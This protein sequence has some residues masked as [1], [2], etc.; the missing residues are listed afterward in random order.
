MDVVRVVL[1]IV[2]LCG[3][4][5]FL[6]LAAIGVVRMPDVFLRISAVSKASTLGVGCVLLATAVAS[7]DIGVRARAV[8]TVA[9]VFLTTPVASHM[10]GRAAYRCGAPLWRGT[11]VD[12]LRGYYDTPAGGN[13]RPAH[14]PEDGA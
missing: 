6:L 12:E 11:V 5:A 2:L 1:T 10:L 7:E 13:R 9:F 3:G 14:D 8:A 4:T